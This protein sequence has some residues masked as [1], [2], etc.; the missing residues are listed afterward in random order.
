VAEIDWWLAGINHEPGAAMWSRPQFGKGDS[1]A[2]EPAARGTCTSNSVP[3]RIATFDR[4]ALHPHADGVEFRRPLATRR[5]PATPTAAP[6]ALL[7]ALV[8]SAA[9]LRMFDDQQTARLPPVARLALTTSG[10]ADVRSADQEGRPMVGTVV[11]RG[12]PNQQESPSRSASAAVSVGSSIVAAG[13][14]DV[15]ADQ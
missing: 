7:T 6:T 1:R 13:D 5:C 9:R 11:F 10:I 3:T 14:L 12:V 2:I 8:Q 4:V 15:R